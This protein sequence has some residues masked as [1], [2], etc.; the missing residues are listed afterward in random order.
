MDELNSSASVNESSLIDDTFLH[1]TEHKY[2]SQCS[3]VQKRVIRNKARKFFVRDGVMYFKK[4]VKGK[5]WYMCLH[6]YPIHTSN[7]IACAL[8]YCIDY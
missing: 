4:I 1:L 6:A 5:V 3:E 7:H 8:T 2:P